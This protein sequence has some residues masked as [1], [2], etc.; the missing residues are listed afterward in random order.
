MQTYKGKIMF[1]K[2]RALIVLLLSSINIC[3][4]MKPEQKELYYACMNETREFLTVL[5]TFPLKGQFFKV[6]DLG[7]AC[8][9]NQD[10]E[11]CALLIDTLNVLT[12]NRQEECPRVIEQ[13]DQFARELDSD[14]YEYKQLKKKSFLWSWKKKQVEN[15]RIKTKKQLHD[16]NE[17]SPCINYDV[18]DYLGCLSGKGNCFGFRYNLQQTLQ[19]YHNQTALNAAFRLQETVLRYNKFRQSAKEQELK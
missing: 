11:Q 3:H 8:G 4:P 13:A 18:L 2:H 7:V 10:E 14:S 9:E 12:E 17:S 1:K 19:N 15:H 16:L 5:H 6:A